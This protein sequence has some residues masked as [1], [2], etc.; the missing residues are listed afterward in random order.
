MNG[1]VQTRDLAEHVNTPE[2]TVRAWRK[3]HVDW[4]A[5]GRPAS[6][7]IHAQFP[8]PVM[9][10]QND[11]PFLIN[12]G[13]VYDVADVVRFGI[14]VAQHERKAGNPQWLKAVPETA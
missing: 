7:A 12:G 6:T 13:P 5:Q 1:L 14:F 8:E 4:V 2:S 3:R 11:E 10:P 9:D